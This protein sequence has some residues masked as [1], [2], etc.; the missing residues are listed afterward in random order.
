LKLSDSIKQIILASHITGVY[1]V[2]RNNIL[3]DDDYFIV[4]N[5]A[6]SIIKLNLKGII[7]HNNFS[8][9]TVSKYQ[10]KNIRFIK[11][12]YDTNFNPNVYRYFI[13]KAYFEANFENID[14]CFLTDISDVVTINNPFISNYFKENPN[15]IFCGDEPKTLENDWMQAHSTHLRNKIAN[16]ASFET[17]FKNEALLNCGIIGGKSDIMKEFIDKIWHIHQQYNFD[18]KTAYTGDMGAF[19][20]IIR[21]QFNERLLHGFPINSIFKEYQIERKDCWFLHK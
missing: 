8:E 18:N 16:Y 7:F 14:A 13:Y 12:E 2:N 4:K 19:N 11:V 17:K 9:D 5:W 3:A 21:T 6:D 1:D 20:Y 10:N 15:K